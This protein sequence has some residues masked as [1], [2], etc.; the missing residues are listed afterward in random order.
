MKGSPNTTPESTPELT[1]YSPPTPASYNPMLT[2]SP[3]NV[4]RMQTDAW[5]QNTLV[6]P[7]SKDLLSQSLVKTPTNLPIAPAV[8]APTA[9]KGGT[10]GSSGL[11]NTLAS[12]R[13]NKG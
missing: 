8:E 5:G 9:G 4:P 3:T 12:N 10:T 13:L 11:I 1:S 6:N 7:Y 2:P